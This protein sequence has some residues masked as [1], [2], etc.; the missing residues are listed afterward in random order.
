MKKREI[1]FFILFGV[2]IIATI[3]FLIMAKGNKNP[4]AEYSSNE[5][6]TIC[7]VD[8][9]CTDENLCTL[10]YCEKGECITR[11]VALCYQND[12]CCPKGCNQINDN[13]C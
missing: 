13:D 4:N 9:D 2:V 3:S 12:G 10:H 1:Y 11:N 8:S 7:N 5:N 6:N